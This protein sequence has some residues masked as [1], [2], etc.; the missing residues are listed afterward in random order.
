MAGGAPDVGPAVPMN[1]RSRLGSL[2]FRIAGPVLIVCLLGGIGLYAAVQRT[3]SRFAERQISQ[4]MLTTADDIYTLCEGATSGPMSRPLSAD[5]VELRI[6]KAYVQGALEDYFRQKGLE[7]FI[8]EGNQRIMLNEELP[9]DLQAA[10]EGS[11]ADGKVKMLSHAGR[12]YALIH[13][14]FPPWNWH[15]VFARERTAYTSLAQDIRSL[16]FHIAYVLIIGFVGLLVVFEETVRKPIRAIIDTVRKG[17][18]LKPTGVAEFDY[19]AQQLQQSIEKRNTLLVNLEKTHFIYAHDSNGNFTY[20][21]PSVN[22][23]LGYSPEEFKTHY[24][25]YLTDHPVNRDVA[26]RTTLSIQGQ[27]QPP[28]EVELY[29]RNG[30][31]RWLK[32]TEVPVFDGAGQVIAV[33]GIARDITDTKRAEEERETL[34]ANLKK[35]MDEIRTLHGIIP[36]CASC[37]KVR[38]DEG[39]WQQLE[40]YITSHTESEFSHGI[41]PECLEKM[42]P[43]FKKP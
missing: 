16:Y 31:R 26:R 35:A 15:I 9:P 6:R 29:H 22:A 32:V 4:F 39:A 11:D 27:Q 30:G 10:M 34:I 25:T 23:I 14:E 24:T 37:R 20:L 33:E 19:L 40:A 18:R 21:S 28:Y 8:I 41:C 17:D 38:D 43:G 5:P 3:F 1:I 42:Y 7:G 2:S 13:A 36:I 12:R